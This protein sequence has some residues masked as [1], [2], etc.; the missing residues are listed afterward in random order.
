L[1]RFPMSD[2]RIGLVAEGPTDYVVVE[3]SLRSILPNPFT[4]VLIQPDATRRGMEGG[5]CGVLKWCRDLHSRGVTSIEN[6][7][8]LDLFDLVIVHVDADVAGESYGNCSRE[9]AEEARRAGL[10]LLPCSLP[11]PPPEATVN[12]LKS[13]VLSWMGVTALGNK[14]ILCLPSKASDAW[15]A[16]AAFPAGH[17]ILLDLECSLT[18]V[19]R[20][21]LMGTGT[22]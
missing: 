19:G 7:P 9:A 13:V 3:A 6:D 20:L 21:D 8:T 18:L 17:S 2:L 22:V 14:T 1:E 16:A 5:W 4:L 11:C 15:L 12:N 10:G